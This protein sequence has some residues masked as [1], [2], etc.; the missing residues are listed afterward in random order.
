ML[1]SLLDEAALQRGA[2]LDRGPAPPSNVT[3]SEKELMAMMERVVKL[4][5]G[6][7]WLLCFG[8]WSTQ[9]LRAV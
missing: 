2:N 8:A 5:A 1:S 9:L 3:M 7:T 4:V 6:M